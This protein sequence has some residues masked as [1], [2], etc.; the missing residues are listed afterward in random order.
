M[1]PERLPFEAFT[2][3]TEAAIEGQIEAVH[4]RMAQQLRGPVPLRR[5]A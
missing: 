2:P 3:W 5:P 4:E 1:R